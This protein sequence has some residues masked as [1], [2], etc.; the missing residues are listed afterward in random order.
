MWAGEWRSRAAGFAD[1]AY[2]GL[3]VL[4]PSS[5]LGRERRPQFFAGGFG[6][7]AL[8]TKVRSEA[9]EDVARGRYAPGHADGMPRNLELS[10]WDGTPPGA[11][12]ADGRA[13]SG[14]A[15]G[16]EDRGVVVYTGSFSSPAAEG[17]V[18]E[19]TRRAHFQL[20]TTAGLEASTTPLRGVVVLFAMTGDMGFSTRRRWATKLAAEG[21]VSVLLLPACYGVRRPHYQR[22]HYVHTVAEFV[23]QSTAAITEGASLLV[24][25]HA[26]YPRGTPLGF[27]GFSWGGAMAACAAAAV[28]GFS[29]PVACVSCMGSPSPEAVIHGILGRVD[30]DWGALRRLQDGAAK[31]KRPHAEVLAEVLDV[32]RPSQFAAIAARNPRPCIG[33]AR[34]IHA[35]HDWFIPP[36]EAERLCDEMRGVLSR[37]L[38]S[39][40]EPAWTE[41]GR[42]EGTAV[43]GGHATA[44]LGLSRILLPSVV[45]AF[46]A[47]PLA[48][49]DATRSSI[50]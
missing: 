22:G 8:A 47:L 7:V 46:G 1:V 3:R 35:R 37:T 31:K 23:T 26:R 21:F 15:G 11:A 2:G 50:K 17:L 29:P 28:S 38:G 39:G 4:S 32:L 27:A 49:D 14:G 16:G 5:L 9:L 43:E 10:R 19:N 45:C 36:A 44:F 30:V 20:V 12:G 41:G 33:A 18:E 6:D 40:G 48:G 34:M 24:W 25:L 13:S 42:F